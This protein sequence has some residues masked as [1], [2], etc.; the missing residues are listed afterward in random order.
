MTLVCVK[1]ESGFVNDNT[2]FTDIDKTYSDVLPSMIK[3]K[4]DS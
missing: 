2:D 1:G 4:Y 3:N